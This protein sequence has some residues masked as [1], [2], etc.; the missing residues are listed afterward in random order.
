MDQGGIEAGEWKGDGGM[1]T[2]ALLV[3]VAGVAL[4]RLERRRPL[5]RTTERRADRNLRNLTIAAL[6]AV[7][8]QT[9]ERPL[10]QRLAQWVERNRVGLVYRLPLPESLR[11]VVVFLL[12]DYTLYLWHILT[13]MVPFLWCMHIVHHIDRDL[14]L[15]TGL[16]FHAAEL[17]TSVPWRALQIRLIG[18]S[19][20]RL[21]GWQTLTLL[22]VL[23]H[24][25]NVR[26]PMWLE[27]RLVWIVVTP[28]MHGIHHSIRRH[29]TDS[30][31]SSGLTL[32][33]WLHGTLILD[34]PQEALTIGVPAY[35]SRRDIGLCAQLAL[36]FTRQRPSWR[37]E[38]GT[39]PL[40]E[41]SLRTIDHALALT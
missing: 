9:F 8:L 23:F 5:R 7:S 20:P 18:V 34:V 32:W 27:R 22:S 17:I 26:L 31:W 4:W 28:R 30:N 14:S 29:E 10:V 21:A 36:P 11:A 2:R 40:R 38:N 13:H 39:K 33:D 16:R 3:L 37:Y 41:R 6:S 24:H 19:P 12:L 35:R 25:S 1:R 15:T